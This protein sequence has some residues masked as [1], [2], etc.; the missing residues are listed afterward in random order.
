[1]IKLLSAMA[2]AT[3]MLLVGCAS[4]PATQAARNYNYTGE[5]ASELT[6]TTDAPNW[7]VATRIS[8]SDKDCAELKH[9]GE[10]FYDAQLRGGGFFGTMQSLNFLKPDE[11]LSIV[12]KIPSGHTT[13]LSVYASTSGGGYD[14]TCGPISLKFV[15]GIERKYKAYIGLQNKV[16]TLKVTDVTESEA[17]PVITTPLSCDR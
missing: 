17:K 12:K 10:L 14:A 9:S 2:L 8:N 11:N 7:S 15:S 3:P 5:G 1:M 6:L 4:D 13:Q 16:C